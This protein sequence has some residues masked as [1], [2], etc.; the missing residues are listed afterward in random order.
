[1]R[2]GVLSFFAVVVLLFLGGCVVRQ[3]LES[4]TPAV[5]ASAGQSRTAPAVMPSQSGLPQGSSKLS[6]CGDGKEFFSVLPA[7]L[8]K[9]SMVTPVGAMTPPSHVFPAPHMYFYVI[10]ASNPEAVEVPVYASGKMVLKQIGLRHYNSIGQKTDY[11]DYTLVFS[12]CDGFELYFHHLRSLTY[13]P[14]ADAAANILNKCSFSKER[15]ED[16]CSGLVNIPID[17]GQQFATAGDLDGGVYGFDLGARDYRLVSGRDFVDPGR[18]CGRGRNVFDRCYVVCPFDYF[19]PD[20]RSQVKFS[21]DDW[22]PS[23]NEQLGCGGNLYFDVSGTAQGYW[24]LKGSGTTMFG[25]FQNLYVGPNNLDP[26]ANVFSVGTAVPGLPSG[27]YSFVPRSS[28]RVNRDFKDVAA[29]GNVYCYEANGIRVS[30]GSGSAAILV[31]LVDATQLRIGKHSSE[32]CGPGPWSFGS[33][34]DF[35][36]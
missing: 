1:M 28:G 18:H 7:D 23:G 12:P 33:Y 4:S 19:T 10:D 8:G 36:R 26:S 13:L 25:E 11:L 35:E 22:S 17:A 24:F 20:V 16:Y 9:V 30:E 15:N 3:Q 5:D 31:S 29:D 2:I 27:L 6:S 32:S 34:A 21:S 14:F